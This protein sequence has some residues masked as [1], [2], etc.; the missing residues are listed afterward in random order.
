MVLGLF[1]KKQKALKEVKGSD[2]RLAKA[3]Q[4]MMAQQAAAQGTAQGKDPSSLDMNKEEDWKAA[5]HHWMHGGVDK[6]TARADKFFE[7]DED[8]GL[9]KHMIMLG[10][11]TF[12]I[13]FIVWA[14]WADLDEVTRGQGKVIPS[15]EV[16]KISS[17]EGGIVEEFYVKEGDEVKAGQILVRL[18]DIA[19]SSELGSNEARMFGL[20]ATIARLQAEVEGRMPQ[21]PQEVME[22]A[23]QSVTEEMNAYRANQDS[24]NSQITVIQ[25]QL[26][27]RQQELNELQQR[28]T[29]LRSQLNLV[30]DEK[31]MV[32]PLVAS[33][34][35]PKMELLQLDRSIKEK[36]TELNGALNAIPRARAA[37]GEARN[38][39]AEI[40]S[41][42]KAQSQTELSA[43]LIEMNAIKKGLAGIEDRKD[44]AEIRSPVNGYIK[45]LKVY[46]VGGVVQPGQEFIEIVPKDDQL[47]VEAQINP[48]DIAWLY[49]DQKAVVKIT[50]YDF[51]IYGG[52]EGKLVSISPDAVTNEK[53]DSFYLVRVLTKENALK[54]K[55]EI[56]PIIP[57]MVATVDIMTGKKTVMEYLLKPFIK[58]LDKAMNER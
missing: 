5:Q 54:H 46:T 4:Q 33:G 52:L 36:E 2:P 50:A 58:T 30:K 31:A 26:S 16:Q 15:S 3:M 35:A 13:A 39:I 44:R 42:A 49:P 19:A 56:L 14:N 41:Q 51:S 21:F 24:V 11:I 18:S 20:Q 32:A 40:K 27:Q 8:L 37:V 12:V 47:L 55:D 9:G 28:S 1:K 48:K 57:G 34:S 45:D 6:L 25:S 53:G 7:T 22:N 38:R 29:D 10:V 43:K 23:P 17:L